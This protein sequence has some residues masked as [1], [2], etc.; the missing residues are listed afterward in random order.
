MPVRPAAHPFFCRWLGFQE[1]REHQESSESPGPPAGSL[2]AAGQEPPVPCGGRHNEEPKQPALR[3]A[4]REALCAPGG[5]DPLQ[6]GAQG[7][8]VQGG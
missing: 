6:G 7:Q 1:Q 5:Q 2:L 3:S 8:G 4:A